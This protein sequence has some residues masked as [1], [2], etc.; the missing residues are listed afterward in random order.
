MAYISQTRPTWSPR[1]VTSACSSCVSISRHALR[2]LIQPL[3]SLPVLLPTPLPAG[4]RVLPT[5]V[6]YS[7]D[8]RTWAPHCSASCGHTRSHICARFIYDIKLHLSCPYNHVANSLQQN[9]I[10]RLLQFP[11]KVSVTFIRL[12][13]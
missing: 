4:S 13:F 5:V 3:S 12:Q 6:E 7:S 8:H 10:R 1:D 2:D 11:S 9:H